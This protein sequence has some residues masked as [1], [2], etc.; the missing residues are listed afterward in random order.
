MWAWLHRG[1]QAWTDLS[2]LPAAP[3]LDS[4]RLSLSL[5][6]L[7]LHPSHLPPSLNQ[8]SSPSPSPVPFS[9]TLPFLR[10]LLLYHLLS[11]TLSDS[12]LTTSTSRPSPHP[13]VPRISQSFPLQ[14][15]LTH[16]SVTPRSPPSLSLC[17]VTCAL[18]L[19]LSPDCASLW[20]ARSIAPLAPDCVCALSLPRSRFVP[21]RACLV[22]KLRRGP[23][24]LASSA[25]PASEEGLRTVSTRKGESKQA[26][27]HEPL[28]HPWL[29]RSEAHR[30]VS[31][32][33]ART[34][35]R[36]ARA[37]AATVDAARADSQ[38]A[39]NVAGG[40]RSRQALAR[41]LHPPHLVPDRLC[42]AET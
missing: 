21:C 15:L 27:V 33:V 10:P 42:V 28:W 39:A 34:R 19:C 29:E 2:G 11:A 36:S 3:S 31:V 5:Y 1:W 6:P 7:C 12:T 32:T 22:W 35:L 14:S 4:L 41:P 30:T 13:V 17:V 24:C 16:S 26:A 20:I 18:S 25:S 8:S 40:H 23:A 38:R 37:R 9:V